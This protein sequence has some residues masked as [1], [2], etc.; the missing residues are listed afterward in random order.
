[1]RTPTRTL[2]VLTLALGG[3]GTATAAPVA[4]ADWTDQAGPVARA[5]PTA[6]G[7]AVTG[8][9]TL[10][11]QAIDV[12][13]FGDR[14]FAQTAGGTNYWNPAAPYLS[15]AVDN[16]PPGT[17]IIALDQGGTARVVFS[18][19]VVDPLVAL[20][21]WNGNTVDFGVPIEVLSFGTGFWGGGTP[22]LNA[23]GTGFFGSGEVHGVIRL[24]GTYT[25]IEF[26]HTSENWHGFTV[27]ALALADGQVPEPASLALT[28]LALAGLV[29]TQRRRAAR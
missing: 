8:T 10:G 20:V 3:L 7:A 5:A 21:S 23:A 9:L 19:A 18:Q 28:A 11:G 16:A 6:G 29:A 12:A 4:W 14:L 15:A 2:A 25:A 22:V 26:T 17:D 1:M 24:P 13:Y 27:G